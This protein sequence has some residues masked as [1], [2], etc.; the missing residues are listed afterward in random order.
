[1]QKS[2]GRRKNTHAV[3]DDGTA[4]LPKFV[5]LLPGRDTFTAAKHTVPRTRTRHDSWPDLGGIEA[6]YLTRLR[7]PPSHMN[8]ICGL[9][10][11]PKD[12][13]SANDP[14]G[15]V[16][17]DRLKDR[18][19]L[20]SISTLA[21]LSPVFGFRNFVGAIR[22]A[23]FLKSNAS[24]SSM[25]MRSWGSAGSPNPHVPA[26]CAACEVRLGILRLLRWGKD[27]DEGFVPFI[28]HFLSSGNIGVHLVF[29][30]IGF[31]V[32]PIRLVDG[33]DTLIGAV[34]FGG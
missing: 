25:S 1:M 23:R 16:F 7:T 18:C 12:P 21:Q 27:C 14:S 5:E 34:E 9:V 10:S 15:S 31:P 3:R 26:E 11:H 33:D 19:D 4:L 30:S 29:H 22:T 32:E 2:P 8:G 20:G 28:S 6:G 17:P 13:P 24:R